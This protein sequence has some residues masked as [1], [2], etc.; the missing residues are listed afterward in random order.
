MY[1][2]KNNKIKSQYEMQK[3]VAKN[4]GVSSFT[5]EELSTL[6]LKSKNFTSIHDPQVKR[7]LEL[8]FIRGTLNGLQIADTQSEAVSDDKKSAVFITRQVEVQKAVNEERL[9]FVACKI[10]NKQDKVVYTNL[11][12]KA[13]TDAE[14]ESMSS[15]ECSIKHQTLI[16]CKIVKSYGTDTMQF[17]F[18]IGT[19]DQTNLA[20]L[21][22]KML[23]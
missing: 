19:K 12:L 17:Q 18:G 7:L 16:Q 20:A 6:N 21:G 13:R 11:M 1:E 8:A 4:N 9:Y 22:K 5:E 14:V 3:M 15:Y 23:Q 10:R 2:W